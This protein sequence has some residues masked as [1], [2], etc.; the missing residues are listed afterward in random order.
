VEGVLMIDVLHHDDGAVL[1]IGGLV[2]RKGSGLDG[3]SPR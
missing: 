2:N 3:T 1:S